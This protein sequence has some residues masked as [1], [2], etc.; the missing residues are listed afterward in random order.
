MASKMRTNN[1]TSIS[2][3]KILCLCL[4][5]V[6][7]SAF[8]A[9]GAMA[10]DAE[11]VEIVSVDTNRILEKHPAFR[12]AQDTFRGEMQEMEEQLEGMGQEE[13]QMAQQMMQQQLQ[14]RGQELQQVAVDEVRKDIARIAK[15][16]GYTYVVDV[17]ALIAGGKEITEEV[18]EAMDIEE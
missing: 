4:A 14:Q 5:A 3:F 1:Q 11:K 10:G 8:C 7:F 15:E 2:F 9:V 12:E 16:K 18:M 13:Q 17:N 6:F